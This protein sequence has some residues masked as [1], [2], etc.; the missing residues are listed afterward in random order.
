VRGTSY[1]D[2]EFFKAF[3][4]RAFHLDL[5]GPEPETVQLDVITAEEQLR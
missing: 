4:G 3:E 5:E 1:T 2:P